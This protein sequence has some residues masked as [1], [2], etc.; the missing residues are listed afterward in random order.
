MNKN[1]ILT[2]LLIAV[3][4]QSVSAVSFFRP[5][6]EASMASKAFGTVCSFVKNHKLACAAT[7]GVSALLVGGYKY[8]TREKVWVEGNCIKHRKCN[9]FGTVTEE[10]SFCS[11][12]PE[13]ANAAYEYVKSS[14]HGKLWQKYNL[15][16]QT[17]CGIHGL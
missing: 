5:K 9:V 12:T 16:I 11:K 15:L 4:S 1:V 13:E 7:V 10:G 17:L 3:S 6:V 2:A 14:P 8:L